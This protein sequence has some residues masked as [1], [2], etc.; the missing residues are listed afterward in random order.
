MT[1]VLM[2]L[3]L[4]TSTGVATNFS[5]KERILLSNFLKGL[6]QTNTFFLPAQSTFEDI[7]FDRNTTT[8]FYGGS[9]LSECNFE[10]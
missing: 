4:T 1:I 9:F 8:T 3:V 10:G 6:S 7:L 5:R 2:L